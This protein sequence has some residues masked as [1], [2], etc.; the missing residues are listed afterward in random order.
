MSQKSTHIAARKNSSIVHCSHK[1]AVGCHS[2]GGKLQAGVGLSTPE[3][4]GYRVS[5]KQV[6][7]A[8][9]QK[10]QTRYIF[11]EVMNS[12]TAHWERQE[13]ELD[14]D[15][16][17]HEP[18]YFGA[19]LL[20]VVACPN[21]PSMRACACTCAPA[22]STRRQCSRRRALCRSGSRLGCTCC[23]WWQRKTS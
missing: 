14:R 4:S 7:N 6:L 19:F 22:A 17:R 5:Y 8:V 10:K 11:T 2:S 15:L 18:D 21:R 23:L 3:T 13:Q 16:D 12:K 20:A 9:T 1:L